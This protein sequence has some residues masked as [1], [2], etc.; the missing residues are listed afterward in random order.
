MH[1]TIPPHGADGWRVRAYPDGTLVDIAS[2]KKYPYLFWEGAAGFV[3]SDIDSKGFVVRQSDLDTFLNRKL[4]EC[5]LNETEAAAILLFWLPLLEE[6][7]LLQIYFAGKGYSD[8]APLEVLPPPETVIRVF[9]VARP[10]HEEIDLK[11]QVISTPPRQ[12]F[13]LVEWGG[14]IVDAKADH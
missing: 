7:P 4:S 9:M 8:F 1:I 13:T 6:Y 3:F 14:T 12:G 2:G 5:G 11:P 10:L